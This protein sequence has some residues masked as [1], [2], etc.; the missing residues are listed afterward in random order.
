VDDVVGIALVEVGVERV[1]AGI[2]DRVAAARLLFRPLDGA[3]LTS[4]APLELRV[5]IATSFWRL[6]SAIST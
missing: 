5:V 6:R 4:G 1:H 3:D 2:G